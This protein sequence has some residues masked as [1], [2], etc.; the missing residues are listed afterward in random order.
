M[1]IV[2]SSSKMIILSRIRV[3]SVHVTPHRLIRRII[4]FQ[5]LFINHLRIA[6]TL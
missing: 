3:E 4:N 6:N 2:C 5:E 1:Y